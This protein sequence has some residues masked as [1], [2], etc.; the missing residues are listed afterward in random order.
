MVCWVTDA[1]IGVG[2]TESPPNIPK[3]SITENKACF[4][5]VIVELVI[6]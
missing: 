6:K 3:D 1:I 4:L 5:I 2:Q